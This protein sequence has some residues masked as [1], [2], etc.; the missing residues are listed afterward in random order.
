MLPGLSRWLSPV[1]DILF[2]SWERKPV[3][4]PAYL[5]GPGPPLQQGVVFA[6]GKGWPIHSVGFLEHVLLD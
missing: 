1:P 3:K 5:A 4:N 2:K 6:A